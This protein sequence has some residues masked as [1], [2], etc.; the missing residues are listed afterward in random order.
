MFGQATQSAAGFKRNKREWILPPTKLKENVDY[1][2]QE[3]I[4]K[5]SVHCSAMYLK[6]RPVKVCKRRT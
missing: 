5:V 4:S 6:F 1:T 3:F 2:K